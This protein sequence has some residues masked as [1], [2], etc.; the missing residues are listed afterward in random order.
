MWDYGNNSAANNAP[1]RVGDEL[2]FYYSGRSTTHNEKPNTGSI[3]LGKLR[4]DGFVSV[5]A[6][7]AEGILTVKPLQFKNN[8][9]YVNADASEGQIRAE[10][11]DVSGEVIEPFSLTNCEAIASDSIRH[12]LQWQGAASMESLGDREV[13]LRFHI[14]NA[15][16]YAFWTE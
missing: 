10:L 12:P 4:V 3:G 14:R 6:G 13:R 5:D 15:E 7:Q 11:V 9:L 16:L 2:W 1:I 8:N